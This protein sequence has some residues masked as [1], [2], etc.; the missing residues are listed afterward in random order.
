LNAKGLVWSIALLLFFGNEAGW[1]TAHLFVWTNEGI[2][3]ASDSLQDHSNLDGSHIATH[4]CKTAISKNRIVMNTGPFRSLESLIQAESKLPPMPVKQISDAL[5]DLIAQNHML[6]PPLPPNGGD[7]T[8][9]FLLATFEDGKPSVKVGEYD[10]WTGK[11][12]TWEFHFTVGVVGGSGIP[13]LTNEAYN[14]SLND[15]EY[16]KRI[17]QD[18]K[19]ELTTLLARISHER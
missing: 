12:L 7:P 15:I 9:R 3:V 5:M 18:P 16:R 8:V 17:E 13:A 4:V 6:N 19:K 2:W 1:A 10:I 11:R 14:R